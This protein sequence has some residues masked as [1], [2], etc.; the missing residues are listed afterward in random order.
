MIDIKVLDDIQIK[1]SVVEI[2]AKYLPACKIILFGSRATDSHKNTSDYDIVIQ[3]KTKILST[4]Y[5]D[6]VD[7]LDKLPTLKKIDLSDYY[8]LNSDFRN[9]VQ[10]QGVVLYDGSDKDTIRKI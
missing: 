10:K 8:N 6:I 2:I 1:Q 4:I 3:G 7:E 5:F 9:T